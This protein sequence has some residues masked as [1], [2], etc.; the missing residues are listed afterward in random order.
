MSVVGQVVQALLPRRIPGGH[1]QAGARPCVII[2]DF[3]ELGAMRFPMV[4]LVPLTSRTPEREAWANGSPLLY[5][6]LR[7]GDGKGA[8]IRDSFVLLD[9]ITALDAARVVGLRGEL[10]PAE[11]QPIRDGLRQLLK[12]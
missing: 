10:S 12:M 9:Q 6:A 4:L 1:E 8:I 3:A 11:F 2:G 7:A 5:P